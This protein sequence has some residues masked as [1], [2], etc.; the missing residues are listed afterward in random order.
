MFVDSEWGKDWQEAV[1]AH[2]E[3]LSWILPGEIEGNY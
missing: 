1:V 2:F 3:V